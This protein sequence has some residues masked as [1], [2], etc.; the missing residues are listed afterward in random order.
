MAG[1][2]ERNRWETN[3]AFPVDPFKCHVWIKY[4]NP[5]MIK[6]QN[7]TKNKHRIYVM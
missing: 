3:S 6:Q 1:K 5:N 4:P 7:Q 2:S